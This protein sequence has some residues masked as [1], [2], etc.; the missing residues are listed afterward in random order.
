M[1]S[2]V[3]ATRTIAILLFTNYT[4]PLMWSVVQGHRYCGA[5]AYM[6][7]LVTRWNVTTEVDIVAFV[8]FVHDH[9]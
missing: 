8:Q 2:A 1:S 5:P 6:L 7:L 4:L 3:P 9:G